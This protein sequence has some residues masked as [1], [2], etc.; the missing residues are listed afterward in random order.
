VI[1]DDRAVNGLYDAVRS[2]LLAWMRKTEGED[3]AA[4]DLLLIAKYFER[5]G[6]HAQ[7]VAEWVEYS[8]T[9]RH[10]GVLIT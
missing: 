1:A 4:I 6:D 3:D 7:N 5:V 2:E 9:G 8:L 10:K